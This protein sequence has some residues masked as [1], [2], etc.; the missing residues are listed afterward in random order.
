MTAEERIPVR[1][2]LR[3]PQRSLEAPKVP[4]TARTSHSV[5]KGLLPL[6][7]TRISL[8]ITTL[9]SSDSN[10]HSSAPS[11]TSASN[12]GPSSSF[13]PPNP[14]PSIQEVMFQLASKRA[15][16]S[17][18]NAPERKR[19]RRTCRKCAQP[20]C[21]G[22][23]KVGN[24]RNACRDCGEVNCRGRNSKR[25]NKTCETGWDDE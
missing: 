12:A 8:P 13:I 23:Q 11:N 3:D 16:D 14:E 2:M 25:P 15:A 1:N 6:A 20:Q 22:S 4:E 5:S 17:I 18:P 7:E 10:S 19:Q 24:C 9:S 21:P